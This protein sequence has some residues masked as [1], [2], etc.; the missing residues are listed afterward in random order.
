MIEKNSEEEIPQLPNGSE[1][2]SKTKQN[3]K[4]YPSVIAINK[5]PQIW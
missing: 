3:L 1:M 4:H 5:L 2:F